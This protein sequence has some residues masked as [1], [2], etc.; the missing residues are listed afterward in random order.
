MENFEAMKV[1]HATTKKGWCSMRPQAQPETIEC[2]TLTSCD[3]CGWNPEVERYR[4]RQ[5]RNKL[6]IRDPDE[7][8]MIRIACP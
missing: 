4:L 6:N 2:D 3:T 7:E 8:H 5:A 1:A